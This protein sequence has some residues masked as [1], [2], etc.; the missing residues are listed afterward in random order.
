MSE[1]QP[2][3]TA[4]MDGTKVD[5]WLVNADGE[6][7]READ[8]YWVTDKNVDPYD[9]RRGRRDGW[10][11]P[12]HD[13]DGMDGWCDYPMSTNRDGKV[14]FRKAIYWMPIPLPP[15]EKVT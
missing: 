2:I 6:G 10:F 11:A 7:W 3:E 8:A 4:P 9:S 12:N 14:Y 13:Y 15:T 5:L 1:W